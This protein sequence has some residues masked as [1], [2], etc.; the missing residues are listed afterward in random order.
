LALSA[1]MSVHLFMA[2]NT[3]EKIRER[4]HGALIAVGG[5][6]FNE[7]PNLAN[8]V[9]ADF[10]APGPEKAMEKATELLSK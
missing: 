3:I 2:K 10:Y 7:D 5:Y 9:G 8:V 1:T 4:G 6:V